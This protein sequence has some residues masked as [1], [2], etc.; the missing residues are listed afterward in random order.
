MR[1]LLV[2][3]YFP[4]EMGAPQA[5]LSEFASAWASAGLDVTVLTGMPNLQ[6]RRPIR[7]PG[8]RAGDGTFA[9]DCLVALMLGTSSG[10]AGLHGG[11]LA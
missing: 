7:V 9:S 4:P 10:T 3:H 1:V 5:R 11:D 6:I 8:L 2:T